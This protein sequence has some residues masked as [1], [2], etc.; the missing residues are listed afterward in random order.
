[1]HYETM[2]IDLVQ[3]FTE[4]ISQY[5]KYYNSISMRLLL[6]NALRMVQGT[7]PHPSS[8]GKMFVPPEINLLCNV[9][10]I[11]GTVFHV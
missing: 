8:S 4:I 5:R 7:K 11:S 1:M 10:C 3:C 2:N 9:Y 6:L